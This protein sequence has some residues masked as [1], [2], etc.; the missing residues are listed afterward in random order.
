MGLAFLA[1]AGAI[2]GFTLGFSLTKKYNKLQKAIML[3]PLG[4]IL[5]PLSIFTLTIA[6]R[7]LM[8]LSLLEVTTIVVAAAIL[9]FWSEK[10]F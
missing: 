2:L 8:F 10:F 3:A 9:V 1:L 6:V 7:A 5:L 4:A